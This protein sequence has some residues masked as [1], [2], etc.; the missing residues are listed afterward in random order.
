MFGRNLVPVLSLCQID[1]AGQRCCHFRHDPFPCL[2]APNTGYGSA[3]SA[4]HRSTASSALLGSPGQG[5]GLKSETCAGVL[6][7]KARSC[8]P[9]PFL[10][11]ASAPLTAAH[12]AP[13]GITSQVSLSPS[14]SAE[15]VRY[16]AKDQCDVH[17]YTYVSCIFVCMYTHTPYAQAGEGRPPRAN[18]ISPRDWGCQVRTRL[19]EGC[20]GGG[21]LTQE[22]K[23]ERGSPEGAAAQQPTPSY[24]CGEQRALRPPPRPMPGAGFGAAGAERPCSRSP[25]LCRTAGAG[26]EVSR[27]WLLDNGAS[28]AAQLGAEPAPVRGTAVDSSTFSGARF[29]SWKCFHVVKPRVLGRVVKIKKTGRRKLNFVLLLLLCQQFSSQLI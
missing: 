17:A 24:G 14:S 22:E 7:A 2:L 4:P 28:A 13:L 16:N 6:P 9:H 11:R 26:R 5:G 8:S 10:L 15:M 27:L 12:C 25:E 3:A 19:R 23:G 29:C 1:F 18:R 21:E 20:G